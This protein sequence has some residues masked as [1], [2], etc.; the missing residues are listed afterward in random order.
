MDWLGRINHAIDYLEA[1]LTEKIDYSEAANIAGCS[2]TGF[3]NIFIFITQIT[4]SEYVRRRRMSLSAAELAAGNDKIIDLACKYCYESAAA[5]AR[6]FKAF[7]GITPSAV[8]RFKTYVD[9]PRISFQISITGGHYIMG[10]SSKFQEYKDILFKVERISYKESL[11][12]AGVPW[13]DNFR[14]IGVYHK[15]Y[16]AGLPNK[17][18]PFYDAEIHFT[19]GLY[20]DYIF[21]GL[22]TSIEDLP[23]GLIGIDTGYKT[24]DVLTFR[25]VDIGTLLGDDKG[26]GDA[27]KTAWEYAKKVWH[28]THKHEVELYNEE[29]FAFKMLLDGVAYGCGAIGVYIDTSDDNPEMCHFLPVA[30][31][32]VEGKYIRA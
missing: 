12:I 9:Y 16:Q 13:Q 32:R 19:T 14:N 23:E 2:L 29:S 22:V 21:G 4:P 30:A 20:S 24:F 3:Q 6:S 15:S 8:Q 26:P 28:P 27:M 25:A 1:N 31:D 17:A 11:K 18:D 7:H 10:A 5:Y